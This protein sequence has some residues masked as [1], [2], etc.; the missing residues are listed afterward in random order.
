VEEGD[1]K[2]CASAQITGYSRS[3]FLKPLRFAQQTSKSGIR[4]RHDF[5][6]RREFTFLMEE[7]TRGS[8]F[9]IYS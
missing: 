6:F 9:P 2:V 8:G 3:A 7:F 5:L 1:G 4:M